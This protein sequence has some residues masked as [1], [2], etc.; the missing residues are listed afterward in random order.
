MIAG[1]LISIRLT[2]PVDDV[3]VIGKSI[4]LL[5][6]IAWL[7]GEPRK[8]PRGTPLNGSN[9]Q[10]YCACQLPTE[11]AS[12]LE[13]GLWL[14]IDLFKAQ[15]SQLTQFSRS[16]GE[17]SLFVSLEHNK[18]EGAILDAA[19]LAELGRLHVSIDIDRNL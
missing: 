2:H 6:E 14:A 10:S 19:L 7:A 11:K 3:S 4:G 18:F 5:P 8:T 17:L 13:E 15:E 1:V 16:G 9:L 12:S